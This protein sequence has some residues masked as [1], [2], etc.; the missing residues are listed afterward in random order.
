MPSSILRVA[1]ASCSSTFE[2]AKP[3]WIST[4]SPGTAE[5][6]SSSSRPMFTVRF[7]PATSTCAS[8]LA[9]STTFRIW[10]GIARHMDVASPSVTAP[11]FTTIGQP[12]QPNRV[13]GVLA[14][15]HNLH[16]DLLLRA[17]LARVLD[18]KHRIER[19]DRDRQLREVGLARGQALELDAG[20]HQDA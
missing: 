17:G 5:S 9:S 15:G 10:P 6:P 18:G 14:L 2:S 16:A 12:V 1:R 13:T 19:G 11:R 7:T 3:T 20:P 8:R 4:Q